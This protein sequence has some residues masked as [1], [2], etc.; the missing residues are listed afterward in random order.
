MLQFGLQ[1][2]GPIMV[3]LVYVVL[4]LGVGLL[5]AYLVHVHHLSAR[6]KA[7][8]SARGAASQ[9]SASEE[10]VVAAPQAPTLVVPEPAQ[11]IPPHIVAVITAAI[12]ATESSPH[13]IRSV[14]VAAPALSWAYEGRSQIFHSHRVR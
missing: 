8:E 3:P 5:V 6:R 1:D 7:D 4:A 10:L 2:R 14:A 9:P 13:I 11:G 12:C